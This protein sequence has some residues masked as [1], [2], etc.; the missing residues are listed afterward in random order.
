MKKTILF[1]TLLASVAALASPRED[2]SSAVE[3]LKAAPN[4]S[5]TSKTEVEGGNFNMAPISGKVDKTG[6]AVVSQERDGNTTI[7]VVKGEKGLVK[8]DEGWK[9]G[10]E[11]RAA[12]GGGGGGQRGGMRGMALL[13]SK[14]PA[15]DAST[16]L[17]GVQ[18]L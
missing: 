15:E 4:Y 7:A 9:T 1:S 16:I 17:K 10:E 12:G 3:K 5:W 14:A 2:V 11:L 6:Y 18:E 8:T 13:R